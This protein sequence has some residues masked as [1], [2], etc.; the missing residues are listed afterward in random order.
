MIDTPWITQTTAR[1]AAKIHLTIP[2]SE[3]RLVM[4]PALG[5]IFGAIKKQGIE[6]GGPWF[7]H[8]LKMSAGEFDF[9]VCVPVP[10]PVAAMGRVVGGEFPAVR[11][12]RTI[13]HGPY[14]GRNGLAAAWGEFGRWIEDNGHRSGEDLYECYL[15]GPDTSSDSADWRTELSKP[16]L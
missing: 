6:P 16:L 15:T 1:L 5:E 7:T 4:G 13:H 3:V 14:D 10:A 8:H 2:R 11:V 12:A 9:E